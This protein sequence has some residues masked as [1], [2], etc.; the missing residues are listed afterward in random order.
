MLLIYIIIILYFCLFPAMSLVPQQMAQKQLLAFQASQLKHLQENIRE[1][2]RNTVKDTH[3]GCG[4]FQKQSTFSF[5]TRWFSHWTILIELVDV[6]VTDFLWPCNVLVTR[7]GGKVK[8]Q[9]QK[10]KI[11]HQVSVYHRRQ[12][13]SHTTVLYT[14]NCHPTHVDHFI[15]FPYFCQCDQYLAMNFMVVKTITNQVHLET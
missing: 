8:P 6:N 1:P 11:S 7:L 13:S 9:I 3:N 10:K 15:S 2:M 5:T 4:T 14:L 12:L